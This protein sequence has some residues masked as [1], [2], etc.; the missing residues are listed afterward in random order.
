MDDQI[1]ERQVLTEEQLFENLTNETVQEE[2]R[3]E[4]NRLA[5]QQHTGP[6]LRTRSFS[7]LSKDEKKAEE[8]K[9]KQVKARNS[10]VKASELNTPYMQK[11][12]QSEKKI[13]GVKM[14]Q[15]QLLDRVREGDCSH[16]QQLDTVLRN[17]AATE[18]MI[19]NPIEGTPEEFVESLK[20][21]E[22]PISEMM[23]PLLRIGISQVMNSKN[24]LPEVVEKYRK[25]DE[26]LNKEIMIATITKRRCSVRDEDASEKDKDRNVRS[27]IFIMKTLLSSHIGRLQL[28]QKDKNPPSRDWPYSM[29]NAFAHCSRVMITM[30]GN[31]SVWDEK[32][33]NKM[34]GSFY[35]YSGFFKRG[36]A[37]HNMELKR[38]DHTKEAKEQKSFTAFNQYGMNIAVGG[39]GNNGIPKGRE[40]RKLKN[41]GSCGH[42]F[43]HFEKGNKEKYSGML[44]GFESD[45]FGV[46]NQ[47]G[48]VHDIFATGEFASSFGG[49]RC[50]EIGDKYGGREVDLSSVNAEAYT[51]L[52][53]LFDTVTT[54]LLESEANNTDAQDDLNEIGAALCGN[55]MDGDAMKAFIQKLYRLMYYPDAEAKSREMYHN[56]Y[57][58]D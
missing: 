4:E 48:H 6:V 57:G 14:T 23:N 37:T 35:G 29:A 13:D 51:D 8:E 1:L 21:K 10:F 39:L 32:E 20:E 22:N 15:Q 53:T 44:I 40:A 27:Q 36:G 58:H 42:L 33:E 16:L 31:R 12:L 45:S 49:Q 55:L 25:I 5:E 34:L 19:L 47:T 54:S 17:R 50:D 3:I 52:M 11:V 7:S 24:V 9:Y 26:L 46:M 41:D 56:L 2:R 38:K 30:P 18:Y 28:K 43:M